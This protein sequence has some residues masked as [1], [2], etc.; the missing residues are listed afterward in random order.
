MVALHPGSHPN[1]II[2]IKHLKLSRCVCEQIRVN[3]LNLLPLRR[4]SEEGQRLQ[5]RLVRSEVF[6][7]GGRKG[8]REK[9]CHHC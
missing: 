1:D 9:C 2:Q 7:L 3:E 5:I 6:M 4:T 8:E